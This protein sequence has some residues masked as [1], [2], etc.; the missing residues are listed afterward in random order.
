MQRKIQELNYKKEKNI[1][2][3][4]FIENLNLGIS[5][6]EGKYIARMDADDISLPER[7]QKQVI[8][9]ENNPKISMI[10]AQIDFI[11]EKNEI[12]GEKTGALEHEEIVKK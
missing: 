6:A 5:I 7:F 9:L 8:F 1:G 10:G 11:N 4:G 2:I 12:I 3:K